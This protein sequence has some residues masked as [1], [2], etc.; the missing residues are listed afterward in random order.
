MLHDD[1]QAIVVD[2]GSAAPVQA[3]LDAQGRALRGILVSQHPPDHH[4]PDH[5]GGLPSQKP[6][7]PRTVWVADREASIDTLVPLNGAARVTLVGLPALPL[8]A[9]RQWKNP[10]Q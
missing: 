6:P 3:A 4:Q 8:G 1:R 2:P 9:L 7:L 5:R 10:C